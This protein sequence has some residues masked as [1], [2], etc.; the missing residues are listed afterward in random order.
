MSAVLDVDGPAAP[1]R[2]NGE[3]VFAAPWESRAFG[4]VLTLVDAGRCTYEDF[5]RRLVARIGEDPDRPYYESWLAGLED[6][7]GGLVDEAAL[8]ARA[9]VLRE[10]DDHEDHHP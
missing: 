3:L 5:R 6:V 9:A 10:V 2:A 4:L 7:L 8:V 1:P